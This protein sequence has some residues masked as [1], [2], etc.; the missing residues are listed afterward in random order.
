MNYYSSFDFWQPFK[1]IKSI[2]SIIQIQA[3]GWIWPAG[4]MVCQPLIPDLGHRK[5]ILNDFLVSNKTMNYAHYS[6]MHE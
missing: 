6:F 5:K 1:N 3:T 4:Y 2:L